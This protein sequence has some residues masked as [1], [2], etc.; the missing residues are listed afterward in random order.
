MLESSS[1][2]ALASMFVPYGNQQQQ[3]HTIDERT[4]VQAS[5]ALY[6][7]TGRSELQAR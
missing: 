4:S 7:R 6:S 1:S 3:A 2:L 5:Q